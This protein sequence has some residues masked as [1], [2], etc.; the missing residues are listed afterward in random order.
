MATLSTAAKNAAIDAIVARMETGAT[1]P[2]IRFGII[3]TGPA[4]MMSADLPSPAFG[5]AVN[6]RADLLAPVELLFSDA[7]TP[8]SWGLHSRDAIEMVLVLSGT[9]GDAGSGADM[10]WTPSIMPVVA[11]QKLRLVTLRLEM[12]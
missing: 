7:G 9:V 12:L 8:I 6:G 11:L 1:T 4:F 2:G 5:A 10:E 3:K